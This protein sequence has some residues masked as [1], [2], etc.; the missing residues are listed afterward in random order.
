MDL[1]LNTSMSIGRRWSFTSTSLA[2]FAEQRCENVLDAIMSLCNK[3]PLTG[4]KTGGKH[5]ILSK[6]RSRVSVGGICILR[7]V[8]ICFDLRETK[9]KK[10]KYPFFRYV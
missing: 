3:I 1:R 6:K 5:G 7:L 9:T 8:F 4:F 10:C 2:D